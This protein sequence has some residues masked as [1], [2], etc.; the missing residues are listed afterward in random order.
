MVNLSA[1][2]D[3]EIVDKNIP[4]AAK[5]TVTSRQKMNLPFCELLCISTR[6]IS[7]VEIL[8]ASMTK[9][10]TCLSDA[11]CRRTQI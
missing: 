3:P 5:V 10:R 4:E 8:K 1:S 7:C 6:L 2:G 9:R 11:L